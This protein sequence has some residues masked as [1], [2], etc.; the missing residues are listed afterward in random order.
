MFSQ[1]VFF[2][3][4]KKRLIPQKH[5][6]LLK[7]LIFILEKGIFFIFPSKSKFASLNFEIWVFGANLTEP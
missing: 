2:W 5:P 3:Q 6:K 7:K 1:K 4:K